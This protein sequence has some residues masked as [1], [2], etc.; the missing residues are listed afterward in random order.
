M[1]EA[2]LK[3][4][5]LY[6]YIYMKFFKKMTEAK[7]LWQNQRLLQARVKE[8]TAK[9]QHSLE[10]DGNVLSLDCGD[11]YTIIHLP[12]LIELYILNGWILLYVNY[13]SISLK[14]ENHLYVERLECNM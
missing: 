12:K 3:D 6:D 5:T 4:Y 14:K 2:K 9:E 1:K 10:S 13:T 8:L 7:L 11:I